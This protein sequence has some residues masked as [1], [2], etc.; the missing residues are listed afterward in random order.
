ML[1]LLGPQTTSN[2]ERRTLD[3]IV[4]C[5]ASLHI[6]RF[7]AGVASSKVKPSARQTGRQADAAAAV[8]RASESWTLLLCV[9][10]QLL[11]ASAHGWPLFGQPP[12]PNLA[13]FEKEKASPP[14]E[15]N[16]PVGLEGR[17]A[18]SII[19]CLFFTGHGNIIGFESPRTLFLHWHLSSLCS[20][21]RW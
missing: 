17:A 21:M 7:R 8:A 9:Y 3:F 14:P 19:K 6:A 12:P 13:L 1:G 10:T 11:A 15:T 20:G 18:L 4:I 2:V 5:I 16:E